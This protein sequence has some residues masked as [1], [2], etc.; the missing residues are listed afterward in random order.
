MLNTLRHAYRHLWFRDTRD[1]VLMLNDTAVR[2]RA[3]LMLLVPIYMGYTL[4]DAIYGS[5]WVVTGG[6]VRDTFDVDF[7]GHILYMV[8]AIRRTF[9]Y[10]R[11]SHVLEY[12]LFEMIAGMFV[13]TAWLS[14]T[15]WIAG[16]L[17]RSRPPVWKPLVPKRF[18]WTLGATF[19]CT[20]WVF[21][22]PEVL[23]GWVN[24]VW[25]SELLPTN[26]NYMPRWIPLTLVAT[27]SVLMWMEAVLGFCLGCQLHALFVR[28]GWIRD[29]CEACNNLD[30]GR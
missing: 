28:L 7:D 3:G 10:S 26:T 4:F 12:A 14:P 20:C 16:L 19:I 24:A 30:F 13:W 9:D 17:A 11:Q 22:N 27:C 23:A 18:A 5:R 15:V 6:V 8:E 2:I 25:T 21:F 29:E 1:P